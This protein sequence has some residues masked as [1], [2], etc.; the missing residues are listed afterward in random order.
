MLFGR[1]FEQAIAAL[2]RREDPTAALFEQWAPCKEMNL[3]YSGHD[4]WDRMLQQCVQLL[5]SEQAVTIVQLRQIY[6]YFS[7]DFC[8]RIGR[9]EVEN[10]EAN[11]GMDL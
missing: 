6:F 2:F 9:R 3:S 4:N 7:R 1:A 5:E 10:Y 8:L 11:Q